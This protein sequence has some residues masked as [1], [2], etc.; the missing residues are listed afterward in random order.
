MECLGGG[1]IACILPTDL[2]AGE[3]AYTPPNPW[4]TVLAAVLLLGLW[5]AARLTYTWVKAAVKAIRRRVEQNF[6]LRQALVDAQKSLTESQ[7]ALMESHDLYQD[8]LVRGLSEQRQEI[9]STQVHTP[10]STGADTPA[11]PPPP[12]PTP[13]VTKVD[14]VVK[15]E[16]DN[17]VA[18]FDAFVVPSRGGRIKASALFAMYEERCAGAPVSSQA[19]Y[20]SA[21]A[22]LGASKRHNDGNYYRGYALR[23]GVLKVVTR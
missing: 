1:W 15:A 14:A 22:R 19:F 4:W 10:A 13:K 5:I 21:K 18:F 12:A 8:V 6:Q 2:L 23:D 17:V 7:K 9:A 11:A 16:P 20:R 3:G